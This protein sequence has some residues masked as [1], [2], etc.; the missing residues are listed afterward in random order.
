MRKLVLVAVLVSA[1]AGTARADWDEGDSCKMHYPQL[2][3]IYEPYPFG[4]IDV[5]CQEPKMLA[6][7]FLCTADG[8]I[9]DIHIWGSWLND[10]VG[11]PTF[12]VEIYNDIPAADSQTGYSMPNIYEGPIWGRPFMPGEYRVRPWG[13]PMQELFWDPNTG[14]DLGFDT[15]CWQYNF[16]INPDEAFRQV[17]GTTYWLAVSTLPTGPGIF[18]WKTSL[19]YWNDNAVYWD[20]M[21]GPVLEP[22]EL[23]HPFFTGEP[24]DLSFVITPEPATMCL[25]GAG[26]V[27][28]ALKRKRK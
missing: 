14:E 27:G 15:Q 25:L 24:L 21:G 13:E 8:P 17:E 3:N 23:T 10:E 9:T 28:L 18:G 20:P 11:Q 5:L 4:G 6:D 26:L 16:Y 22:R 2:P 12:F 7:D 19:E 1:V